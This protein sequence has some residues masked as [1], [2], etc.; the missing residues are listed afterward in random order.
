MMKT[1]DHIL[2]GLVINNQDPDNRGR[3]Q[4][5]IPQ[6]TNLYSG[7]NQNKQ[8]IK[9]RTLDS[10]VFSSEIIQRLSDVLPWADVASPFFGGGT[11]APVNTD[12]TE[13]KTN[14]T[15]PTAD[16]DMTLV[17]NE[18]NGIF[19]E[20]KS[21]TS[22][23]IVVDGIRV[24]KGVD[25]STLNHPVKEFAKELSKRSPYIVITSGVEGNHAE[26]QY[27]HS[28][29]YKLDVRRITGL[30]SEQKAEVGLVVAQVAA[31]NNLKVLIENTHYD[32]Q[33]N[34]TLKPGTAT[35]EPFNKNEILDNDAEDAKKTFYLIQNSNKNQPAKNALANKAGEAI[36]NVFDNEP[37]QSNVDFTTDTPETP[38]LE[39]QDKN[40]Q[41]QREIVP[42][43][44]KTGPSNAGS[45]IG[46]FSTPQVGAKAYVMFLDGNPMRPIVI[47]CFV[48]SKNY[49]SA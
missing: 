41:I 45:S 30:N 43:A 18:V 7:W 33:Y 29:G 47:G 35:F 19:S 44:D 13:P 25:I 37:L 12:T 23:T 40:I 27:S 42:P 34:P 15:D 4:V 14:P 5:F 10:D 26:G 39:K 2:I 36:L 1:I 21:S 49:A 3:V 46:A 38:S 16:V 9:F 48:E 8:D 22:D 31:K 17:P 11:A 20:V 32:I 6:L 24:K 28:K